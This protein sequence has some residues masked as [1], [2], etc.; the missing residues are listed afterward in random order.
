MRYL[1]FKRPYERASLLKNSDN[2]SS[3]DLFLTNR[4]KTFHCTTTIET[5]ITDFCKLVITALKTSYKKQRPKIIHY[6]NYKHF[7]NNN[8]HQD[9]K[10]ELLKFDITN[11]PHQ[12]VVTPCYLF[13]TL[14]KKEISTFY[15]KRT[16][17]SNHE[18]IK[19]KK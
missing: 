6:R 15:G 8:F 10:K 7:E 13:L 17:K 9:L 3:T 12:N 16:E 19:T 1:Q 11:A 4:P 14:Q 18:L 5:G 2:P